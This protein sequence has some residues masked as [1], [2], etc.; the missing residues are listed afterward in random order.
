MKTVPN[1]TF[2]IKLPDGKEATAKDLLLLCVDFPPQGG[3]DQATQR[4]RNRVAA[5]LEKTEAGAE[6]SFEDAD[7]TVAQDA[8]KL[9]RWNARHYDFDKF[10]TL[11][12]V[13]G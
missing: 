2:T 11:F 13:G 7:Y 1:P 5:I 10:S 6:L 3:F 12:G 4:A 8:V 9:M